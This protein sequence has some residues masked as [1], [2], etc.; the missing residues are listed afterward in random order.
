MR[1]IFIAAALAWVATAHSQALPVLLKQAV[2]AQ[3]A[4]RLEE[5]AEK[6]EAILEAAPDVPEVRSNLGAAYAALGRYGDAQKQYEKALALRPDMVQVRLNLG[7]AYFKSNRLDD[8]AREFETLLEGDA[9]NAQA[10]RLLGNSLL[11]LGR[12]EDVI[13]LLEPRLAEVEQNKLLTYSLGTAYLRTD[14]LD[15]GRP[16]VDRLFRDGETPE[17][18]LLLGTSQMSAYDYAG[19]RDNLAKAA[20]MNPDLPTVHA[21]YAAALMA[22]GDQA[23]ARKEFEAEI[24]RN[25]NDFEANLQMAAILK[26]ERD[27]DGAQARLHKALEIRPQS[28]A[29]QYQLATIHLAKRESEEARALLEDVVAEA[30]QFTEAHVSLATVYYRLKMKEE[31]DREREIVR[32][33]NAAKQARQPG[34]QEEAGA[35]Y[36]GEEGSSG[37][38]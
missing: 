27:L 18:L 21:A 30:P 35:G 9:A 10:L 22:T 11:A 1:F 12:Y 17:G 19:A 29:A 20:A 13:G 28:L 32:R 5:A 38:P 2:E 31:G 15:K 6:Y 25:P 8:A 3:Q 7:L 23:G 14:Q 26:Q 16:L 4:G 34:S 36:K 37:A 33:L 24:E